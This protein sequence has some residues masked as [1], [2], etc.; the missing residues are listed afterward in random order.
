M[1]ALI[2]LAGMLHQSINGIFWT[3]TALSGLVMGLIKIIFLVSVGENDKES[4]DWCTVSFLLT[5]I[6]IYVISCFC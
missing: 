3:C 1:N 5:A 6:I 4:K 2:N